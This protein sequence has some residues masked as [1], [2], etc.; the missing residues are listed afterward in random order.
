MIDTV[1]LGSFKLAVFAARAPFPITL[2]ND[3]FPRS[4]R[5]VTAFPLVFS[6]SLVSSPSGSQ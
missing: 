2:V 1:V 6:V 3:L 5:I 4:S